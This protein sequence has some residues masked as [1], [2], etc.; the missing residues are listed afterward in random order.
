VFTDHTDDTDELARRL[1][2]TEALVL[3]RERTAIR[4]ELLERLGALRL[5]SQRSVWPHIDVAACSRL[6]I[7]VASDLHA[8]APSYATAEL[9]WGLV[10]AAAR[11]IPAQVD[12]LRGGRRQTHVGHTLRSKTLGV[13]GY[14]RIG[15][16]VARFG[17]AFGMQVLAWGGE[18]SPY[19]PP[20]PPVQ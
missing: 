17:E 10:I 8:G 7:V 19:G 2:S 15:A 20:E 6:G 18:G 14:G 11:D 3:I 13:L 9:T 16:A 5:I 12:S 4:G 1:A